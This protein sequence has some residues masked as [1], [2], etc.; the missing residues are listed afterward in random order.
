M[1][2]SGTLNSPAVQTLLSEARLAGDWV[3]DPARSRVEL[4]A[5][6]TWGLLP[7]N[8]VFGEV[9]GLGAVSPAG[10][11][12]GTLMVTAAS[13]D[14]KSKKR[15]KDLRSQRFF[16]VSNYPH[17]TFAVERVTPNSDTVIATGRLSVRDQTRPLQLPVRVSMFGDD[18]LVIHGEARIN[19]A[20]FGLT[21]NF[22]GMASMKGTIVVHAVFTRR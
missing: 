4:H 1:V 16:D 19:R 15:D 11:V 10:E 7:V 21:W 9:S 3:L 17:I 13:I 2:R 5:R 18:E 8:G 22:L 12:S 6:H 20:D 14:T